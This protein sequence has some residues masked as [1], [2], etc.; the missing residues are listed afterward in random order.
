MTV[1]EARAAAG[2]DLTVDRQPYCD[3]VTAPGG[4]AGLTL[5]V[6]TP[7][8][9]RID[10]IIVKDG[11]VAT[12]SGIRVGATEAEVQAAY[13]GRLRAVNP[14]QPV[15]RLI[16]EAKDPSLADR[17][18]VFVLDRDRVVTIYAGLRNQAEADEICA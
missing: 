2:I 11:P 7:A 17:V 4:P 1:A 15:H 9:G 12:L 8:S 13:P 18:V 14:S 10:L 16:Y 5:I 3:V 6:S